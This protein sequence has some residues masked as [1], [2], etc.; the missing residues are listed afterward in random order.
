LSAF[1]V[2][3]FILKPFFSRFFNIILGVEFTRL[4]DFQSVQE[5]HRRNFIWY[6]RID[7]GN[8]FQNVKYP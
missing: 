7:L 3:G 4:E 8:N 2:F 6:I 1:W 5:T